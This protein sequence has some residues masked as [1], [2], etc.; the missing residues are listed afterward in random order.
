MQ[1]ALAL[2][3]PAG[4]ALTIA[5]AAWIF[6]L[7]LAAAYVCAGASCLAGLAGFCICAPGNAL[8][9][10]RR[11]AL[12]GASLILFLAGLYACACGLP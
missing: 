2:A 5:S 10:K 1:E 4:L 9:A 7:K 11:I 6:A 3:A 12:L 8:S